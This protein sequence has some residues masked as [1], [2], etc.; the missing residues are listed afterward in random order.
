MNK[1]VT[2]LTGCGNIRFMI[3]TFSEWRLGQCGGTAD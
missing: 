2:I 1:V 3:N